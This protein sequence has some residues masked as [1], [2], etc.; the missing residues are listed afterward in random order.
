MAGHDAIAVDLDDRGVATIT[1]DRPQAANARNQQMR[2]ELAEVYTRVATDDAVRVVVLT[3]AGDRHFCAGMDL[4]EAAGPETPLE[5]RTRL[6]ASRDIE[7]LAR[8]PRPT[9][10]AINGAALGGGFEMALA[11]DLRVMADEATVGL[12][13]VDHGLMPGGGG[14]QRLP[15][16]IGTARA[17]E[18]IF[19]GTRLRGPEAARLGLVNRS[20]PRVQLAAAV[21][22]LAGAL[23]AK[24][25]EAL[26]AVKEA[27]LAGAE[28]PLAAAIDRELD[29]LLFLLAERDRLRNPEGAGTTPPPAQI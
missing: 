21:D 4:K 22:E 12:T 23:A 19:L 26:R 1:L 11:C 10:A 24:P 14:T 29:G 17:T 2:D 5:R 3:G 16:L 13:E 9:I 15:R 27:M 28:L 18:L 25:P 20:V 6:R 8:L 7:Q